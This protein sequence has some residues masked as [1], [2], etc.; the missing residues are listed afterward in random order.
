MVMVMSKWIFENMPVVIYPQNSC[1]SRVPPDPPRPRDRAKSYPHS[2]PRDTRRKNE[3]RFLKVG[4]PETANNHYISFWLSG[5]V[6][7]SGKGERQFE[8]PCL[9]FFVFFFFGM[10]VTSNPR[11]CFFAFCFCCCTVVLLLYCCTYMVGSWVVVRGWVFLLCTLCF[12]A[13]QRTAVLL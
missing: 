1:E 9:C 11:L 3:R 10:Y 5:R 2:S 6:L 7:D 4:L 13:A 12:T 8:S